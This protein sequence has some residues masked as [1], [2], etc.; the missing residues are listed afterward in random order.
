V[1]KKKLRKCKHVETQNSHNN[2]STPPKYH[3]SFWTVVIL[4]LVEPIKCDKAQ[5]WLPS[6]SNSDC[7][8]YT[9]LRVLVWGCSVFWNREWEH[10]RSLQVAT[11]WQR[12][13]AHNE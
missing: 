9:L 5:N 3:N 4:L 7:T 1:W 6:N 8:V 11:M 13:H 12:T 10:Y 2:S